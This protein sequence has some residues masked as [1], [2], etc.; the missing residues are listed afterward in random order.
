[1][2]GNLSVRERVCRMQPLRRNSAREYAKSV[3]EVGEDLTAAG[4]ETVAGIEAKC[5]DLGLAAFT[6]RGTSWRARPAP[7]TRRG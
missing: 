3:K 4:K 7:G 6:R 2:E 1:M 5:R